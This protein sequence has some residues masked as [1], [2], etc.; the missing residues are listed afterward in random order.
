VFRFVE[1][2][3]GSGDWPCQQRKK[4]DHARVQFQ[5]CHYEKVGAK[6]QVYHQTWDELKH[7][8]EAER[9][10]RQNRPCLKSGRSA[11]VQTSVVQIPYVL[12]PICLLSIRQC[13]P[14]THGQSVGMVREVP[15]PPSNVFCQLQFPCFPSAPTHWICA[16]GPSL[17][18]LPS[19]PIGFNARGPL[20]AGGTDGHR[21]SV[22][23]PKYYATG[24]G[25]GRLRVVALVQRHYPPP[26]RVHTHG[27]LARF[28]VHDQFLD[29]LNRLVVWW[30]WG[31][32]GSPA[33][34]Q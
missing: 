12:N 32:T 34:H 7:A 4:H 10:E 22:K 14:P 26:P 30:R 1:S 8:R 13:M 15:S 17:Y 16:R 5:R 25:R 28:S 18:I 20:G 31:R 2:T 33:I 21:R 29:I 9:R 19:I 6:L 24:E 11:S 23:K 27:P 3:V